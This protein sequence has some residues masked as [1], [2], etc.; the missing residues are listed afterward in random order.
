[1][2]Y[3]PFTLLLLSASPLPQHAGFQGKVH[4]KHTIDSWWEC[5]LE[6]DIT[7][8]G[9]GKAVLECDYAS[10][11][12]RRELQLDHQKISELRSL[13]DEAGLFEGQFWG[14]DARGWDGPLETLTVSDDEQIATLICTRNESFESGPREQ[15]VSFLNVLRESMENK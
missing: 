8:R 4:V 10:G 15:L 11:P 12:I 3:L 6:I 7:A 13:L 5:N 14:Y 1:M 2:R 9:E